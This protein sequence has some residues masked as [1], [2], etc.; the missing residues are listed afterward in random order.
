MMKTRRETCPGSRRNHLSGRW[1]ILVIAAL[2]A[3]FW[4]PRV[5]TAQS[6]AEILRKADVAEGYRSLFSETKQIITTTGGQ[7]RTLVA[8]FWAVNNGEKQLA[9]Y[10][11]PA[12]IRGQKI[13]MRA[14]G[15]DIWMYNPETRR[16]RK[17][18]SHMRRKR[19]MG[20][21][22]TYE[23]QA[24]GRM[25]EKYN[26]R[27][28]GAAEQG[29]VECHILEL[30][31]TPRGPK[32][33]KVIAWIGK[34]DH[35]TRRVDFYEKGRSEVFKRLIMEDLRRVDDKIIPFRMTMFNLLDRTSTVNVMTLVK[36]NVRI[37]QKIFHSRNL[38]R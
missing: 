28:I 27:L 34:G 22:F 12:D 26:G 9:E 6:A 4:N 20:S 23:D 37:P 15:D 18:G 13:L 35:V 8:R 14:Y 5:L 36:L 10:L 16:T 38:G 7:K 3:S 29:G 24:G 31:P 17:L 1:F 21:D 33:A 25:S 2:S 19:V 30:K 32:Y 11:Q